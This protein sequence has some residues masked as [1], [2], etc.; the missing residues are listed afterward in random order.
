MI[1]N[2]AIDTGG[3]FTDCIATDPEGK[4]HRSKVLS[5]S[6]LRGTVR[7][8][9]GRR[10]FEIE[11]DWRAPD[12]FVSGFD[13]QL[14]GEEHR[15]VRVER[16]DRAAALL[17]LDVDPGRRP[18]PGAPFE[19]RSAEEAP[20]LAARLVTRTPAG[21]AL[22]DCALRLATTRGTNALLE[23]QGA[24][25][26]LFITEGFGDL[27]HIGTQQRPALFALEVEKPRPLFAAVVE[28]P[29]RIAAGGE[30][31]KPL[32]LDAIAGRIDSLRSRGIETAAIA[33]LS[34]YRFPAHEQRLAEHLR[35]AGF[36]HVSVSSVVAPFIKIVP[37]AETAVVD[38]YLAPVIRRY[39]DNVST[40][41]R[42][43]RV[44]VM[45][46]AGG[47]V[48]D[49]S[50]HPKDS[51]LSGPAGGVIGASRVGKKSGFG[52]V[53]SFDMGG[54]STDVARFDDDYE[55]VFEHRIGDAHLVAP[56]LA[57]ESVAAGGGSIC[58]FE[59]DRLRVGPESAG[60]FPG[61][62]CYGAGG[63][64]T[65]TDVNLLLGRLIPQRF[66]IP[67]DGEAAEE[68]LRELL[69]DI[70]RAT[71][72][73]AE[74]GVL[75]EGL[76]DIASERMAEAIRSV[77][78]RRG[79]DPAGYALVAFGGAGG[80]HACGVAARLGIETALVPA[81]AGILSALGIAAAAVERFASEQ[82]LALLDEV[83]ADLPA[84]VDRLGEKALSELREQGVGR[85]QAEVRRRIVHLRF[86]GQDAVLS[87]DY[88]PGESL[89]EAFAEAY[90]NNYGHRGEKRPIEVESVR[91]VASSIETSSRRTA[92]DAESAAATARGIAVADAVAGRGLERV[93][94][95]VA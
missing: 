87:V 53:I 62:A 31:L 13:F 54:T 22:P 75:L 88:V 29:E 12:D 35:Q 23:R 6:A 28:V 55:Y 21:T 20:I 27:L 74:R 63:P 69:R 9:R 60:A 61:P 48:E 52:Q 39:L 3:T 78:I 11:E 56:A 66:R 5:S 89:R 91:V 72:E 76:V 84:L 4:I 86:S 49:R 50:Y 57:I 77:S 15:A 73:R 68:K 70:E 17:E 93:I 41:A 83:E 26:A 10:R 32:D 71:G 92:S 80:Q 59:N 38:A 19:V 82:V 1:W 95:R 58:T 51:L 79:Y 45:T 14:L 94:T 85:H 64:F 30:V 24:P 33:L 81:D 46:S 67:V 37:R 40:A 65:M 2:L 25:T 18:G 43:K 42:E 16:Y 8:A 44:H 47:L 34:S 90:E 36:A 7:H